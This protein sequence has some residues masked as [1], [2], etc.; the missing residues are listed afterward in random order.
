MRT[1][2]NLFIQPAGLFLS[3]ICAVTSNLSLGL[4]LLS[5]F[6]GKSFF[7]SLCLLAIFVTLNWTSHKLL[8]YIDQKIRKYSI[9]EL[10]N[11]IF[12]YSKILRSASLV[13]CKSKSKASSTILNLSHLISH[14]FVVFVSSTIMALFRPIFGLIL[15]TALMIFILLISTLPRLKTKLMQIIRSINYIAISGIFQSLYFFSFALSFISSIPN[16][17]ESIIPSSLLLILSLFLMRQSSASIGSS[18][19]HLNA[20]LK[21]AN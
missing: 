9:N 18:I 20:I 14:V 21:I 16:I 11:Q 1:Y 17:L 10:N 2:I 8:A 7:I 13:K 4:A 5:L 15:L 6:Q 3:R 12:D 19:R